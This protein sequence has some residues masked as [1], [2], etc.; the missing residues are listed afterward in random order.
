MLAL[1][2]IRRGKQLPG[3]V[4]QPG[5]GLLFTQQDLVCKGEAIMLPRL[6]AVWQNGIRRI[7]VKSSEF[8]ATRMIRVNKH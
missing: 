2:E 3:S 4:K 7:V 8:K 6:G 5:E 1:A